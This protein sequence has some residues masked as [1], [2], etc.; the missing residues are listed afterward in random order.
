MSAEASQRGE[1]V[2][3]AELIAALCLATDLGMGFPFEHG[4][5]STLI[6]SRLAER[7]GVDSATESQTY[8]ACLLS[9]AGCTTDAHVTAE[10]FGDSLTTHLHP[11]IHGSG[12]EVFSGLIRSLPRPDRPAPVRAFEVAR[13][14]PKLAREQRPHLTASCEVAGMLAGE[15]GLPPSVADLLAYLT[16]RWDGHGP[17]NRAKGEEIPVAMRIVHVA[18]DCAFQRQL[19]GVEQAARL[20]RE[21]AG[22]AFDPAVAACMADGAEEI[23]A[24]DEHAS[25]WDETL[26]S[27]PGPPLVLTAR[28]SIARSPRWA[29]SP[30]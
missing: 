19:V 14:L 23:L 27:E 1:Q 22:H 6:A 4:L 16:E 26:A 10:I 13:R 21:R 12:R 7:L 3:G 5:H 30:T 17:L 15:V 20:V 24:L 9:H 11:V 18:T 28:N 2:G 8:Y 25:A 29:T